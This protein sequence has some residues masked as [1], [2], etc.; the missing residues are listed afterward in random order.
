M[1][2]PAQ[3]PGVE[4]LAP[5]SFGL[6]M[7]TGIVSLAARDFG[8]PLLAKALFSANLFFFGVLCALTAMRAVLYRASFAADF[9]DHL[10][11]PGFFTAAAAAAILGA[12]CL[13]LHDAI[14]AAWVLWAVTIALW[15]VLTYA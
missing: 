11:A 7:A 14:D 12:Q 15:L 1:I 6:V 10:R 3:R 8:W 4:R 9:D 5:A 2:E 13:L